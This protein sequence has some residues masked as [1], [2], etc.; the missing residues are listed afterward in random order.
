[1][2][3]SFLS[4]QGN[5]LEM[6]VWKNHLGLQ[7]VIS[8]LIILITNSFPNLGIL[9]HLRAEYCHTV[10]WKRRQ[11]RAVNT[12]LFTQLSCFFSFLQLMA[13]QQ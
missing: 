7:M 6:N 10:F 5:V 2:V 11:L 1:M 13:Y 9:T 3:S 12:A 8:C 4:F